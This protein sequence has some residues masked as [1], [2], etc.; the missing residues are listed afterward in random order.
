MDT[1][2]EWRDVVGFEGKY[3]VSSHGRVWSNRRKKY[4]TPNLVGDGYSL[5]TLKVGGKSYYR[6][7]HHLVMEAFS[8]DFSEDLQVNHKDK[9]TLNNRLSNLE[10]CTNQYNVEYSC[11]KYYIVTTP[12]GEEIEVFNLKNSVE[13]ENGLNDGNMFKVVK[14]K[15]KQYKGYKA[16]YK[17]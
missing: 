12:D 15:A 1:K 16:R 6:L 13:R 4:L 9:N 7:V 10:M 8:E 14:G 2:E 3:R 5:V 17:E 11:S